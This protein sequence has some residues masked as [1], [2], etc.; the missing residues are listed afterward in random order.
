MSD[1]FSVDR[2]AWLAEARDQEE[3]LKSFGERIPPGLL[4]QH[5]DLKARLSA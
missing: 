2:E 3:F 4:R 1:L 5:R